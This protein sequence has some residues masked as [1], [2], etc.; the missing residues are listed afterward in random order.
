MIHLLDMIENLHYKVKDNRMK[1]KWIDLP[2]LRFFDVEKNTFTKIP[3]VVFKGI[4]FIFMKQIDLPLL[5]VLDIDN[6][7]FKYSKTLLLESE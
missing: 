4:S 1:I 5:S 6:G 2:Q 3:N 7:S